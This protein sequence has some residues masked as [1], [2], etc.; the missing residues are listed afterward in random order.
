LE[1]VFALATHAA[2]GIPLRAFG[3]VASVIGGGSTPRMEEL[4]TAAERSFRERAASGRVLLTVD[5]AH[6]VDDIS[7]ALV[8]HLATRGAG[9]VV[10]TVRTVSRC[11]R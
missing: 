3:S 5:D 7:A 8:L 10:A 4:Q 11:A 6:L 2:S 9:F 1:V